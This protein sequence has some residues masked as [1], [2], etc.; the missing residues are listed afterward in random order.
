D[1][2]DLVFKISCSIFDTSGNPED[3]DSQDGGPQVAILARAINTATNKTNFFDDEGA[4]TPA[5]ASVAY[6]TFLKMVHVDTGRFEIYYSLP[7]TEDI[8]TWVFTYKYAEGGVEFTQ[9]RMITITD[10]D[11]NPSVILADVAANKNIIQDG[12]DQSWDAS[13]VALGIPNVETGSLRN[14]LQMVATLMKNQK[15]EIDSLQTV[16]RE[17]NIDVYGTRTISTSPTDVTLGELS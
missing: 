5:T 1:S 13:N 10:A 17:N 7:S 3:P 14:W 12:V 16:L 6:P 8:D 15:V 2:G 11:S 9:E 4:I